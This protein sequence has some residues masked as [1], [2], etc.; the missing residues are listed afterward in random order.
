MSTLRIPVNTRDHAQGP[1]DAPVILVEYGDYQCPYC[2][3][4]YEGIKELQAQFGASLCFVFRNFPLSDDH[5]Q[6]LPAAVF[7][8]Y[9]ATHGKFW[10]AH[11]AL[12]ENQDRLGPAFYVEL[13]REL[14]LDIEGLQEAL[15]AGQ[16]ASRIQADLN[17]GLRS[18][19]NGTPSFF[20]NGQLCPIQDGVEDLAGPIHAILDGIQR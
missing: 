15:E 11:D 16:L 18:G 2:G 17:G 5:P 12:Y 20:I 10:E 19:V 13:A 7:A 14:A 8:E 4:A 3:E 9:A 1:L 6:A